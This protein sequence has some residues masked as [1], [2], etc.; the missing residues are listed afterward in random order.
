MLDLNAT[1]RAIRQLLAFAW[2]ATAA[3]D[4]AQPPS[5]KTAIP[6][7][8]DHAPDLYPLADRTVGHNKREYVVALSPGNDHDDNRAVTLRGGSW[9]V[10]IA[11]SGNFSGVAIVVDDARVYVAT[12]DRI[13]TGCRLAAFDAGNGHRL[14]SHQLSG[15][16]PIAHSKYSNRVQLRLI[17]GHPVVFGNE[18]KRYI[19]E[20]DPQTGALLSHQLLDAARAPQ[21]LAEPLY[22]E[23]I[24]VLA[25]NPSSRIGV[26][27]FLARHV[28]MTAADRAAREA[29][30]REA[31]GQLDG[32]PMRNG[33]LELRLVE[34]AGELQLHAKRLAP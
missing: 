4:T 34:T 22:Q 33:R 11:R 6:W 16:G 29:A 5:P 32:L 8:W 15:I 7:Q 2:V 21:P 19:E 12:Y 20:R 26:D 1:M 18:A 31:I 23:L 27:D 25:S 13:R 14:W 30:F 9:S 24:V 3:A 28:L 17:A 10:E